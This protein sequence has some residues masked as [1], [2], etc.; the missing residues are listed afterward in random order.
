MREKLVKRAKRT[1]NL[2]RWN[3]TN[4][5]P[6]IAGKSKRCHKSC[7]IFRQCTFAICC[8]CWCCCCWIKML[9]HLCNTRDHRIEHIE[10]MDRKSN[11]VAPLLNCFQFLLLIISRASVRYTFSFSKSNHIMSIWMIF[12]I[13]RCTECCCCCL[14][15]CEC[16]HVQPSNII[17]NTINC[18]ASLQM[19][20]KQMI[21]RKWF[22]QIKFR[23]CSVDRIHFI[24]ICVCVC[25]M[26]SMQWSIECI[27][28][29][30]LAVSDRLSA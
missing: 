11:S 19:Q 3:W 10:S 17:N 23:F 2:T 21:W 1:Q 18:N 9:V 28:Y 29:F 14:L 13:R 7:V 15:F 4:T 6:E 22:K 5:A 26:I 8:C 27:G 12:G 20:S 16:M 25:R 24:P 30:L